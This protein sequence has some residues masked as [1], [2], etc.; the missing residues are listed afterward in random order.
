MESSEQRHV[1]VLYT[2]AG[3]GHRSAAET[4]Q[5][6]LCR[7]QRYRVTLVSAYRDLFADLDV[8]RRFTPYDAERIYNELVLGQG[9][10]GLFCVLYYLI[11]AAGVRAKRAKGI[12]ALRALFARTRP[13]LVISVMPL[14]NQ[15]VIM[16][17]S[18]AQ[19]IAQKP[20]FL[21]WLTDWMEMS[22]HSWFPRGGGYYA[23]CGTELGC[24]QLGRGARRA[25]E[26]FHTEGLLIR[27]SFLEAV[28][29]DKQST[30]R[31]LGLPTDKPVICVMYGGGG[32]WRMLKLAET[33]QNLRLDVQLLMLCGHHQSLADSLRRRNWDFPLQVVGFTPDVHHYLAAADLFVGKPGPGSVSEALALGLPMLLDRKMMLPQERPIVPWIEQQQ[34]GLGFRSM[35]EFAE[36]LSRLL[37]ANRSLRPPPGNRAAAQLPEIVETIFQRHLQGKTLP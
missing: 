9:R 26:V 37:D 35:A 6:E 8:F 22:R 4:I 1:L 30:C 11:A 32:S 27:A 5:T 14:I 24:R 33:V 15:A 2:D 10:T 25:D 19:D 29:R 31:T 21:I 17:L 18:D 23:V 36:R 13:D 28:V 7:D 34:Y 16:A 3:G 12:T 20:P